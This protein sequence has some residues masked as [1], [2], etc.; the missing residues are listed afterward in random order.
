MLEDLEELQELLRDEQAAPDE[1]PDIL[2]ELLKDFPELQELCRHKQ[3]I[4]LLLEI[5]S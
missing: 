4:R 2:R 1:L 3:L 5:C